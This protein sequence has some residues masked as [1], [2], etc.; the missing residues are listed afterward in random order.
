MYASQL[1][2]AIDAQ[3]RINYAALTSS[4]T[5]GPVMMGNG[6]ISQLV[7]FTPVTVYRDRR[8]SSADKI[9]YGDVIYYIKDVRT[10]WVYSQKVSGVVQAISPSTASPSSVTVSGVTVP[11]GSSSAIY[12]FSDL[13]TVKVGDK[14]TLLLGAG[15]QCVFVTAGGDVY[16]RQHLHDH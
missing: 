15:G 5:Q 9:S 16:K 4:L 10:V 13:G 11:L 2:Y 7:G 6:S 1:G 8:L 14:V 12:D 3:G